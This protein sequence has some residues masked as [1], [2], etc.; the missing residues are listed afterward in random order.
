M[1]LTYYLEHG[2]DGVT[3]VRRSSSD[4]HVGRLYEVTTAGGDNAW[5]VELGLLKV[6]TP[7]DHAIRRLQQSA[8]TPTQTRTLTSPRRTP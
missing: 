6:I 8:H 5:M 1:P 7:T 4:T 3:L 2:P